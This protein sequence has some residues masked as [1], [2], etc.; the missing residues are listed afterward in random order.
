[1]SADCVDS[2]SSSVSLPPSI[3]NQPH[4]ENGFGDLVTKSACDEPPSCLTST[5]TGNGHGQPRAIVASNSLPRKAKRVKFFR[6]GDRFFGGIT[7]PV[8]ADRYR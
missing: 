6:N 2:R 1:M 8:T 4:L 3:N 5:A 7:V